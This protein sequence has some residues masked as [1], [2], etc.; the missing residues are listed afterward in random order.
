MNYPNPFNGATR[1]T[2]SLPVRDRIGVKVYS[3]LGELVETL[4]SGE[5][6]AGDYSV[7]LSSATL[8]SG[9]YLCRLEG[10]HTAAVTK[11]VLLK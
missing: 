7:Y 9:V 11:M 6:E 5:Q 8:A 3:M 1:I 2:Y 4:V 10:D